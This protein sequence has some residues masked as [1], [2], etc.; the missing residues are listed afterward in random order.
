MTSEFFNEEHNVFLGLAVR[1]LTLVKLLYDCT[2]YVTNVHVL[3]NISDRMDLFNLTG[4]IPFLH[5]TWGN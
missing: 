4:I 5:P 2:K 1:K 3:R